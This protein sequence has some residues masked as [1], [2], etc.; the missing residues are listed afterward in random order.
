MYYGVLNEAFLGKSF[1]HNSAVAHIHL[2]Y[3][4]INDRDYDIFSARLF[5]PLI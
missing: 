4:S 3:Y 2:Q 1:M 5:F